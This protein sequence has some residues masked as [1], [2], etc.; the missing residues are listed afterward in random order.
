[1]LRSPTTIQS[2][3]LRGDLA[4]YSHEKI[5]KKKNKEEWKEME[6]MEALERVL[7]SQIVSNKLEQPNEASLG[8]LST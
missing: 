4:I 7:G 6:A 8:V 1:M 3:Q 2:Q 5:K